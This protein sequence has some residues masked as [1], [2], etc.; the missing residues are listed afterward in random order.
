MEDSIS[1]QTIK[2]LRMS[3][4]LLPLPVVEIKPRETVTIPLQPQWIFKPRRLILSQRFPSLVLVDYKVGA[5]S[6]TVAAGTVKMDTFAIDD[7]LV[8]VRDL[9]GAVVTKG[10]AS[11]EALLKI[12]EQLDE[13][14]NNLPSDTCQVGQIITLAISNEGP[15]VVRFTG[16]IRGT[17]VD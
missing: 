3:E 14:L 8:A 5:C 10:L 15:E 7:R 1:I 4:R 6:Q 17:V 16:C 13:L 12:G 2:R 11:S 9:L